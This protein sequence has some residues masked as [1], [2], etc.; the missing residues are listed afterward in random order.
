MTRGWEFEAREKSSAKTLVARP[1]F[2]GVGT[3]RVDEDSFNDP[4]TSDKFA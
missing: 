1:R 2:E 4:T 3:D